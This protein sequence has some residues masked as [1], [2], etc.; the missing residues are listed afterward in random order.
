MIT[1][2]KESYGFNAQVKEWNPSSSALQFDQYSRK[3]LHCSGKNTKTCKKS[4]AACFLYSYFNTRFAPP[5]RVL[6]DEDECHKFELKSPTYTHFHQGGMFEYQVPSKLKVS[7]T[8]ELV[9][10]LFFINAHAFWFMPTDKHVFLT[11]CIEK[12][13]A[14]CSFCG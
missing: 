4:L 13:Q 2:E 10:Q 3:L 11:I 5:L 8:L 12:P 1:I 7:Y 14:E 9:M 6:A